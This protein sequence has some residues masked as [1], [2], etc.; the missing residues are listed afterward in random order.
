VGMDKPY[1]LQE[2]RVRWSPVEIKEGILALIEISLL[3]KDEVWFN[4]LT[5]RLFKIQ[6]DE[7]RNMI[8]RNNK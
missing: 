7:L 8:F 4:E 2:P 1:H 5:L 6:D 3:V